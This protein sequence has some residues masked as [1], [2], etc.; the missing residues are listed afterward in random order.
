MVKLKKKNLVA[1]SLP[2]QTMRQLILKSKPHIKG[3]TF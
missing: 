2:R 3:D 1:C